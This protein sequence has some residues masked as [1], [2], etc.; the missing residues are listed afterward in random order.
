M[1]KQTFVMGSVGAVFVAVILKIFWSYNSY[2]QQLFGGNQLLQAMLVPS[3]LGTWIR[4]LMALFVL[5]RLMYRF[6]PKKSLKDKLILVTGGGAGIGRQICLNLAKQGAHLVIWDMNSKGIEE[7]KKEITTTFPEIKV[8]TQTVDVSDRTCVY[9]TAKAVQEECGF[10]YGVVNN[11]GIVSGKPF[12]EIPDSKI[13]KTIKV[14]LLA[15]VWTIKAFLP[16]MLER[17]EGHLLSVTSAAGLFGNCGMTDYSASKFGAV[18]LLESIRLELQK[19]KKTGIDTTIICPAHVQTSLFTG[20][21][22]IPLLPSLSPEYVG[23]KVV[24]AIQRRK[25]VLLMP[26]IGYLAYAAK[27]VLPTA[28]DDWVKYFLGINNSMDAFTGSGVPPP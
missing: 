26:R 9:N 13:E 28:V 20:F 3:I 11:A 12:L 27:G 5:T 24:E 23:R 19:M 25:K 6:W 10:V 7:V 17:N 18:G 22:T 1:D 2:L 16:A 15:H 8:V 4:K 21:R 14:N